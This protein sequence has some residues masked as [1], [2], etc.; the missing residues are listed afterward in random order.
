MNKSEALYVIHEILVALR[1]SVTVSGFFL[2]SSS[3]KN[4]ELNEN[5]RINIRCDFDDNS[6]K[7]IQP[8]L[9]KRNLKLMYCNIIL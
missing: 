9:D 8:V 7:L 1:D 3:P 6:R 5:F 4:S 2:D